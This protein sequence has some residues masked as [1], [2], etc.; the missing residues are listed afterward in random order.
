MFSTFLDNAITARRYTTVLLELTVFL[1]VKKGLEMRESIVA[2]VLLTA[3]IAGTG[4]AFFFYPAGQ[5]D[6]GGNGIFKKRF[7]ALI[8][9]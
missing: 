7:S 4:A 3:V 8:R 6:F 2:V 9:P 5:A 1:G